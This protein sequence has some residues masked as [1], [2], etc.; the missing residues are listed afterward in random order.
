[1]EPKSTIL[2]GGEDED[3]DGDGDEEEAAAV[4]ELGRFLKYKVPLRSGNV[5]RL[6]S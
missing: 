2:L 1:M 5:C 3:G 6:N 4:T